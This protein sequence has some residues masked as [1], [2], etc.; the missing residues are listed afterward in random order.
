MLLSRLRH[1]EVR[2][3]RWNPLSFAEDADRRVGP[4]AL[5]A[6]TKN[7]PARRYV[8]A[9]LCVRPEGVGGHAGPPLQDGQTRYIVGTAPGGRPPRRG[10][11]HRRAT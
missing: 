8:G 10:H 2:R 9:H 11:L 7:D 1:S 4:A 6:M 3:G 5:L